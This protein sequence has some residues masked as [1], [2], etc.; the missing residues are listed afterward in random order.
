MKLSE[1]AKKHGLTYRTALNHFKAG[2]ISGAYQLESG[3]IV[4]P[5]NVEWLI[6][7]VKSDK[8]ERIAEFCQENN[9]KRFKLC[10]QK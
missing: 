6:L 3:A 2:K 1:Y 5:E 4:V 9:I 7:E 8:E 10:Q